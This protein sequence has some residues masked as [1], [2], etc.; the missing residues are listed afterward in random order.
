MAGAELERQVGESALAWMSRKRRVTTDRAQL[1]RLDAEIAQAIMQPPSDAERAAIMA[2][3]DGLRRQL[4]SGTDLDEFLDVA[5]WMSPELAQVGVV[6]PDEDGSFAR[7]LSVAVG[8]PVTIRALHTC[9]PMMYGT[10]TSRDVRAYFWFPAERQGVLVA[11]EWAKQVLMPSRDGYVAVYSTWA[12]VPEDTTKGIVAHAGALLVQ[13]MLERL[14]PRPAPAGRR[15]SPFG[16][17]E[18][19][20]IRMA[21]A[22]AHIVL[23]PKRTAEDVTVAPLPGDKFHAYDGD[24]TCVREP[25]I[26]HREWPKRWMVVDKNDVRATVPL[27]AW[28]TL[29]RA[30]KPQDIHPV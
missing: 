10:C 16:V 18:W 20:L 5:L 11:S 9:G 26:D 14:D 29:A 13:Y 3:V 22:T 24:Y 28:T 17:P 23:G 27:S 2:K 7:M 19:E 15:L 6:S 25:W 8:S 30:A 4:G 1:A 12:D 21:L